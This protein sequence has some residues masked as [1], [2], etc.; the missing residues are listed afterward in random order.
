MDIALLTSMRRHLSIVERLVA[1]VKRQRRRPC[2]LSYALNQSGE[3]YCVDND[4]PIAQ[5][6]AEQHY[7]LSALQKG[8]RRSQEEEVE[9]L[10]LLMS[11]NLPWFNSEEAI[12]L[13]TTWQWTA[14]CS[15]LT[16]SEKVSLCHALPIHATPMAHLI[17]LNPY[18][19]NLLL[20]QPSQLKTL[21]QTIKQT[22]VFPV[23]ANRQP[24]KVEWG[25]TFGEVEHTNE[26]YWRWA[27]ANTESHV[28]F[29]TNNTV[30][31][32]KVTL[33]L[34]I[35][36]DGQPNESRLALYFLNDCY[37]HQVTH[38]SNLNVDI[39][40]PPGR[41]RL[42]F[43][44]SGQPIQSPHDF[45]VLHFALADLTLIDKA[46]GDTVEK[47]AAFYTGSS[48]LSP[49]QDVTI[50][51]VLHENGFFEVSAIAQTF[52]DAA[53]T[54]LPTTRFHVANKYYMHEG[55]ASTLAPSSAH[56]IWYQAKRAATFAQGEQHA[57]G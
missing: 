35:W 42:Q 27:L 54:V 40:L 6:S 41:H 38:Q 49:L 43:V 55:A 4:T 53:Q 51:N 21:A 39:V 57:S 7:L 13:F 1:F 29:L 45:R 44:Y 15:V 16:P 37:S 56:V 36:T 31:T 52:S 30:N 2:T 23:Y 46:S 33:K 14:L 47:E 48:H 3:T 25:D 20:L 17:I 10:A 24:L 50:R 22:L 18:A 12:T 11:T 28:I 9:L 26:H 34:S 5:T 32:K 19:A 8:E